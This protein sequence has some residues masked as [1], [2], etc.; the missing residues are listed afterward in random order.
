MVIQT[1]MAHHQGMMILGIANALHD[2]AMRER[3]HGEPI[4]K[5]AELLLQERMPRDIAVARLPPEMQTGAITFFDK[6]PRVPRSFL[7]PNTVVPRTHLLSNGS[8]NLMIT[9]AGGG[10]SRWRGMAI[11]RWRED[12]TRDN[13]GSFVYLRDV[14]NNKVW[15]AGYHPMAEDADQYE[16]VFS[17]DRAA[18]R[19][20]DGTISTV[21]EVLV[22][23]EDDSEVRRISITNNGTRLR[24]FDITSYAELALARPQDD[25]AHQAFS[26]L[27]VETEYLRE[28]G[29]LLAS[30]RPRSP[31]EQPIWAAHL[32]VAEGGSVGDVQYETDRGKFLTRNRSARTAAA[33][34]EGWPLSNS[35]GAVLD[36]IFSLRRRVQIPRGQ[37]VTVAFWTMVARSRE[38]ITDLVDRHHDAA[39]FE[40]AS[41]LAATHAQ[42]QLQ[43]LGIGGD[44]AHLFQL[45]ANYLIFHDAGLRASP[46]I[47]E[48][49]GRPASALWGAG[50]SG[51][52]PI[53]LVRISEEDE[54][55]FVLQ[56]VSAHEYWRQKRL[57]VDLVILNNRAS[58]YAQDLQKALE[59]VIHPTQW[60]GGGSGWAGQGLPAARRSARAAGA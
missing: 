8:Y 52:L 11:T 24:E 14:N 41:T 38:E 48:R 25:D 7:T 23:S 32:S 16:A 12:T 21:M 39:A 47:L 44:D 51:D 29:A 50:I 15:S 57:P 17:E 2:G 19:R 9:A 35:A 26:K 18:I 55:P 22:S 53:A 42:T 28:T 31:S 37:T 13:W 54:V 33:I 1:Y 40:R 20:S 59:A 60:A 5:A 4:V 6:A 49:G 30:R 36:P 43:Y 34:S 10:Y 46:E 3:F 45:L 56:M 58:S 27:F